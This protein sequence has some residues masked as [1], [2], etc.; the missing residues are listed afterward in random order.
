MPYPSYSWKDKL[1]CPTD[2]A[3]L[4]FEKVKRIS[5]QDCDCT[6]YCLKQF[7]PLYQTIRIQNEKLQTYIQ[8]LID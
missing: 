6:V 1:R 7:E 5:K 2:S 8:R 3:L 4:L